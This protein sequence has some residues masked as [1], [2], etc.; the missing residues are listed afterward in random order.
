MTNLTRITTTQERIGIKIVIE[1]TNATE[2]LLS[3][4]KNEPE[5]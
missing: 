4:E 5:S 2:W 3:A 1:M